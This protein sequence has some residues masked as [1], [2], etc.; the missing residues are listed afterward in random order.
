MNTS[1]PIR[2]VGIL[3]AGL[4]SRLQAR[5][6]AKPLAPVAGK[7]LLNHLIDRLHALGVEEIACALRAELLSEEERAA[8]PQAPGLR[9]LFVNT[10]SSLHT[11]GALIEAMGA[12]ERTLFTMAD[13]VL[14][15]ADLR[16]FF[17]ELAALP[18]EESA[19]L[20]TTF[21]DDEK[22]LWVQTDEAGYALAF[23]S[24]QGSCITSGM[25]FLSPGAMRVAEEN[26]GAGAHKMRNFLSDLSRRGARVKTVVV[27]KTIDVDHPS[28]LDLAEEFLRSE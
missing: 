28:D 3:G 11:L 10:E 9:Y 14:R 21:V 5:S 1:S 12:Q 19:V 17:R 16:H 20:T 2:R 18:P 22:P 6:K 8:L 23:G 26:L 7:T 24:E 4:G 15:P 25:Y 27:A 13:T